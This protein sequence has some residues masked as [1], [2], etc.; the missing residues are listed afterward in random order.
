[1]GLWKRRNDKVGNFSKGMKQRLA[2]ARALLHEPKVLFLDEPT[3]GLDPEIAVDV[4]KLIKRLKEEGRTIFLCTHNLE[5]AELLCERIA[6]LKTR[7]MALDTPAN[8]RN[9][10]FQRQVIVEMESIDNE[11][12]HA[13]KNL[14]FVQS[15][16]QEKSKLLVELADFDKNRPALVE[17]I[18]KTGGK[19]Q[20]VYEKEHSLEE[21]YL[22]LLR[23]E[24]G[25][26]S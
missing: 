6:V 12:I 21:I 7:L 19:I 25:R 20:S 9:L 11:I 23:E 10:M 4:R 22:T 26:T 14:A 18:V 17:C 8:L 5:E 16:S 3:S 24:K 13:V 1:M 15:V 2:L